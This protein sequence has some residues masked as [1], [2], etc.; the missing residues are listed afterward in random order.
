MAKGQLLAAQV[1]PARP[2]QTV[3]ESVAARPAA[4]LRPFIAGYS[5][6]RQAGLAPAV[7]RGMPSPYLTLIFTLNEPLVITRHPDPGQPADS[8]HTLAGGLHTRAALITHEGWQSGIQVALSPLGGRALLGV[9]AGDLASLDVD[10]AA[11]LGARA[12]Q[13]Q[14]RLQAQPGWA[15]RFAALDEFLLGE[16]GRRDALSP[17]G[18]LAGISPEIGFAWSW[19]LRTGGRVGVAALAAETGWSDRHLRGRFRA[20]IGLSP[21]EAARVIRFDRSR[22]LLGRRARAGGRPDLAGLAVAGGYYDQAHLDR[23]FGAL[24]GCSP[25]A[26]LAEEFRNV[27]DGADDWLEGSRYG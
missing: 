5:G 25:T 9:P 2:G 27:Q 20:E 11:L 14:R 6:Y 1:P 21:K 16:A 15:E 17:A 18:A 26:W 13:L 8:Y 24:A 10:V 3:S 12:G 23:E 22:R 19:L 4:G 7:H